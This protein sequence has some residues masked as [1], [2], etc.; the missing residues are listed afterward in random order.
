MTYNFTPSLRGVGTI[1]TDFAETEVD[2]RLVNLTRFPL[3]LPEKRGVLP[4]RRDLLRLLPPTAFF[5]RPHRPRRRRP[6]AAHRRRRQADRPGRPEDIGAALRAHR[7]GGRRRS[8]R[9][10]WS[11]RMRRRMLRQSYHRRHLHRPGHPRPVGW[12]PTRH[13]AGADFRLA[14]VNVPRQQEPRRV[15]LLLWQLDRPRRR[16]QRGLGR[17]PSSTRTTSGR[18]A[19]PTRRCSENTTRPW[20]SR[21]GRLPPLQPGAH[22]QPAAADQPAASAG[23][24]SAAISIS[25]PTSRTASHPRPR[26]HARPHRAAHRR[27][28]RV[29][30]RARPTNGS[31]R[32]SR[33]TAGI[34][35]PAGS[36]YDFIRYARRVNTANQRVVALQPAIEWGSFFSGDRT[37]SVARHRRPAARRA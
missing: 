34:I 19:W 3:F 24:A 23:S 15:R 37:E 30:H 17:P 18:P 35:L 29:R 12:S 32:T 4:R 22:L 11:A 1:N 9:T 10:S 5:S 20:A 13:T 14:T 27:Q 33:S 21:R 31:T 8:A 25:T 2:Q 6:A 36:D 16:R 28:R 26:L 7:R